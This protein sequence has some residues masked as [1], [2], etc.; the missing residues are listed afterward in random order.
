MFSENSL[1]NAKKIIASCFKSSADIF[2]F[3][4]VTAD[5]GTTSY[6]EVY[7]FTTPCKLSFST[8]DTSRDTALVSGVN[9]VATLFI[10][11]EIELKPGSKIVIVQEEI[12]HIFENSGIP[13]RYFT[14]K[15]VKLRLAQE[16]T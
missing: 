16:W 15:E 1:V 10:P 3:T 2:E 14:H 7:T 6:K 9:L 11:P 4:E 12:T 5:D 13:L 8:T